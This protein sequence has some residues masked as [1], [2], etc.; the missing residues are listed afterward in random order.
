[1]LRNEPGAVEKLLGRVRVGKI[2]LLQ[3]TSTDVEGIIAIL[4]RYADQSFDLADATL[5]YLSDRE[6]IVSVFTIDHRHFSVYRN[7]G[8][9][10]LGIFPESVP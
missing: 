2:V 3:L 10:S 7:S 4:T 5:M 1:M 6:G 8:G 9:Q